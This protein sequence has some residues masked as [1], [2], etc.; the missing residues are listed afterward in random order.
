MDRPD[1]G[2]K[3]VISSN[4]DHIPS[5]IIIVLLSLNPATVNSPAPQTAI[6][7]H[8][9]TDLDSAHAVYGGT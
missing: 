7:R 5:G 4:G 9:A 6:P 3:R 2:K 8:A 1:E